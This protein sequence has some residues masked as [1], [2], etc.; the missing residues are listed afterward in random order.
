MNETKKK[1]KT[2]KREVKR[3]HQQEAEV[4]I[5]TTTTNRKNN[6][7]NEDSMKNS[8]HRESERIYWHFSS[9]C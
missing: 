8:A 9:S 1:E 3:T 7:E 4:R 5:V 2:L 6:M